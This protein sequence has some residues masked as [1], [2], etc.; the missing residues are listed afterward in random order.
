MKGGEVWEGMMS[1]E[2]GAWAGEM[3]WRSN[4]PAW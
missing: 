2:S 3:R 4:I 1:E